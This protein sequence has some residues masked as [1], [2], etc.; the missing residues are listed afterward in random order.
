MFSISNLAKL[1]SSRCLSAGEPP[2]AVSPSVNLNLISASNCQGKPLSIGTPLYANEADLLQRLGADSRAWADE[3]G[4][5]LRIGDEQKLIWLFE[6]LPP[7]PAGDWWCLMIDLETN[8]QGAGTFFDGGDQM[9]Q[10]DQLG[11]TLNAF[12]RAEKTP[13]RERRIEEKKAEIKI[14]EEKINQ[15][16]DRVQKKFN[17]LLSKVP[18]DLL[19]HP[20]APRSYDSLCEYDAWKA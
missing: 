18:A 12:S 8:W 19:N 13:E 15:H 7:F 17:S 9:Q 11:R 2:Q 1:T 4:A 3:I 10:L 5:Q 16:K 6:H 14:K 20:D